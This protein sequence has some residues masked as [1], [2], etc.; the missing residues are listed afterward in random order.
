[1]TVIVKLHAALRKFAPPGGGDRVQLQLAEGARVA[2][3]IARLGIP[4]NF[5][6]M[7]FLD[8]ERSGL[9]A[10]LGDGR[11]VSLFPPLGGG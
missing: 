11:E 4:A 10:K 1:M 6:G 5:T 3:A 2:D 8:G 9:A 7:V